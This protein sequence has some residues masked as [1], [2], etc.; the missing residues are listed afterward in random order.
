[1]IHNSNS[2]LPSHSMVSN[3]N[4]FISFWLKNTFLVNDCILA[5][6]HLFYCAIVRADVPRGKVAV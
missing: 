5:A 2:K 4:A 3:Q 6:L 1:M